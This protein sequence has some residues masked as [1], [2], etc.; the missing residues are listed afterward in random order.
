MNE[1][2]DPG[3]E[4]WSCE[5]KYKQIKHTLRV[6]FA[7]Q[8]NAA[9]RVSLESPFNSICQQFTNLI[10]HTK[11][12]ISWLAFKIKFALG[13]LLVK[14]YKRSEIFGVSDKNMLYRQQVG[15]CSKGLKHFDPMFEDNWNNGFASLFLNSSNDTTLPHSNSSNSTFGCTLGPDIK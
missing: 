3:S 5:W 6:Q 15:D 12:T 1:K 9:H 10:V 4:K 11:H 7:A 2:G 14:K 13:G 8:E